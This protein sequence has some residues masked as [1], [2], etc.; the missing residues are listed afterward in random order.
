MSSYLGNVNPTRQS[1]AG[2]DL[3]ADFVFNLWL[4]CYTQ[5]EIAEKE[6]LTQQAIDEIIQKMAE[7]PEFV[8]SPAAL[9]QVDF[10]I[11]TLIE[12]TF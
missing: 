12:N 10:E 3:V 7:L 4:A 2:S 1:A 5:E 8:K 6:G 9:H 11:P